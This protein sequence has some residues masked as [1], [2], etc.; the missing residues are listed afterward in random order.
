MDQNKKQ[1]ASWGSSFGFIMAAAGSAVGLGN[2]WKFPYLAGQNGGGIFVFTYLVIVILIGFTMM[3]GEMILG[4]RTKSDAF[5][6]YEKLKSG[7]GWVGG[8][9]I[10]AA[11]LILSFYSVVGGWVLKYMV[12]TITNAIP[13]DTA[14]YFG[15]FV[16]APVEPLIYHG[17][18]MVLTVVI[19]IRGISGG[20]EKASKLMMPA[21]LVLLVI[22]VIRAVTLP[23]A[24]AGLAYYLQPDFSKFTP[25]VVLAAI[26]QVFF[27]LSLGMGIIITY[28]SYLPKDE[29]LEKDAIIVPSI[30]TLVAL[31]AGFA[32]LPA[33]F[34][35]GLEPGQ[36]AGLLF[37]TLPQVFAQMPLGTVFGFL[38]FVLVLFAAL[39][40]SISLLE[41]SVTFMIDRFH[42]SRPK[43]VAIMSGIMFVIGIFASLSMGLMSEVKFPILNM[44]VFDALDW[45]T[46]YI[47]LPVG[48]L[49][50]SIFI[51]W[52]WNIDEAV[53]EVK[54][55]SQFRLE[56]LWRFLIRY[57]AP[58][59]IF[60]VLITGLFPGLLGG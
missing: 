41:A 24:G 21:L 8:I 4:R 47:M 56:K 50:M 25:Q 37:I 7:W 29:D 32:I 54:I 31:L 14:G 52:I 17:I 20:I 2:L 49:M 22:S 15:G 33:V 39:S 45:I 44:G 48:G 5:T 60:I 19:V 58:V 46:S 35:F 18:F 34:A 40:S 9:G 57:F 28:G 55:S 23:G 27:S 1:R 10:L 59:A 38:F 42:W 26:G 11:F 13:A 6:A 3:L 30:D 36:G 16:S 12:A 43:A 53:D 51:G